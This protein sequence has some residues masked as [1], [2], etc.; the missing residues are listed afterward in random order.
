MNILIVYSRDIEIND[1]GGA[2]TTIQLL[3]YLVG[4]KKYNCYATFQIKNGAINGIHYLPVNSYDIDSLR[5]VIQEKSIDV[6]FAPEALYFANIG[7]KA[8]RG[9][10]CKV[11]TAL[12]N[13]PGYEKIGLFTLLKESMRENESYLKR[14]RAIFLITFYPVF[15][16]MYVP[17]IKWKFH[18]AYNNSDILVLLSNTFFDDFQKEY[19]IKNTNKL[20]AIGN[21]LSFTSFASEAD[22]NSKENNLLFVGR[23]AERHKRVSLLLYAWKKLERKYPDWRFDIVGSGRSGRYYERLINKL[24]LKSVKMYANQNPFDFYKKSSIFLMSSAFEGWGMTI[25]EAKQMGCVP[26]VMNTFSSLKTIIKNGY[27]GLITQNDIDDFANSVEWLIQH[28]KERKLMARNGIE[29]SKKF[30]PNIIY[31]QYAFLFERVVNEA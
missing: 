11:V 1:S 14:L 30:E 29:T 18:N 19:F 12:H 26:V 9:L 28:E 8:T 16:S 15:Y 3:N 31:E 22:I 2:R 23:L 20:Y 4:V 25:M 21:G 5:G 13:M 17:Y 7:H 6:F 10:K 27:D 24:D